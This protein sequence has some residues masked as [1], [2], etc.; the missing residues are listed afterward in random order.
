MTEFQSVHERFSR[1]VYWFPLYLCGNRTQAEDITSETFIRLWTAR[2]EIRTS[3]LK[4]YLLAIA[5]N[6][7]VTELR[8]QSRL[9]P[10]EASLA[11]TRVNI[12][13]D[14]ATRS[15]LSRVLHALRQLPEPDRAALLMRAERQP[16]EE[17]AQMLCLSLTAVKVKV[18]RARIKL[19]E[20]CENKE[21]SH[22]DHT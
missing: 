5:R 6:I 7:Y 2:G 9:A 12:E 4:A 8:R 18:H 3:T 13:R 11:D 17:I 1:D 20:I 16:Y 21:V 22:D 15:S 10:I 14:A 19:L